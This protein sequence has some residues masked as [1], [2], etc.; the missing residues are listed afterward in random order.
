MMLVSFDSLTVLAPNTHP[1]AC[2]RAREPVSGGKTSAAVLTWIA[3]TSVKGGTCCAR[4]ANYK[5][6]NIV[7]FF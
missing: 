1:L 4:V 6:T 7:S 3:V 2:A 5:Q